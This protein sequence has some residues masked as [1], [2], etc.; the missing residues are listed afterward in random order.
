MSITC[1]PFALLRHSS[2]ASANVEPCGW[3]MKSTWHVVPP[4]AAAV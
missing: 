2:I 4:N 3:M 1:L